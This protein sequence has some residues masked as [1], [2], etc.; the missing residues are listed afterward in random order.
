MKT[1]TYVLPSNL[2]VFS[3]ASELN[4]FIFENVARLDTTRGLF[5]LS[6]RDLSMAL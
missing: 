3:S 1:A 2:E 5:V 6:Q 4:V